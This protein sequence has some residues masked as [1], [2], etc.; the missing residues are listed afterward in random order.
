MIYDLTGSLILPTV[1]KSQYFHQISEIMEQEATSSIPSE[2]EYRARQSYV[3]HLTRLGLA[4]NPAY[5]MLLQD[6]EKVMFAIFYLTLH[7][8]RKRTYS[9]LNKMKGY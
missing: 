7:K 6:W 3:K 5:S 2:K 1:N 4:I 9:E 8:K